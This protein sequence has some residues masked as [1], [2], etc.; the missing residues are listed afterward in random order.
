MKEVTEF[1][2]VAG[3]ERVNMVEEEK[4]FSLRGGILD[5]F[6]FQ[7]LSS[8]D[9]IFGDEIDSIREF[10]PATQRSGQFGKSLS[11]SQEL[12]L[13]P[14]TIQSALEGQERFA[15]NCKFA[16]GKGQTEEARYLQD[17][18]KEILVNLQESGNFRL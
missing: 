7:G 10:D 11:S 6:N 2:A 13:T 3:Y 5:I 16:A 18:M 8:A 9:R 15:E 17:K 1:L 4:Q 12:I 14:A